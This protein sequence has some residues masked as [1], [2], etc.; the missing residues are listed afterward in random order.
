[1]GQ[2]LAT[3]RAPGKHPEWPALR[4]IS[5]RFE[6]TKGTE[7]LRLRLER[8]LLHIL[9]GLQGPLK[10]LAPHDESESLTIATS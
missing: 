3:L 6:K 4:A 10:R 8:C 9:R 5:F 2:L 7:S 1:L